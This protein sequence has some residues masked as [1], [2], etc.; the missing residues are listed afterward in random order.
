MTLNE[1][2]SFFATLIKN[3][4]TDENNINR[5]ELLNYVLPALNLSRLTDSEEVTY[6]YY[7]LDKENAELKRDKE[8]LPQ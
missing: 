6:S 7:K 2:D 8:D 4:T 1:L 3:I 5:T